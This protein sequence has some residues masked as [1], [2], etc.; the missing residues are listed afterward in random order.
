MHR[1]GES[2]G[3]AEADYFGTVDKEKYVAQTKAHLE[4]LLGENPEKKAALLAAKEKMRSNLPPYMPHAASIEFV[5][6]CQPGDPAAPATEYARRFRTLVLQKLAK[7][8]GPLPEDAVKFYTACSDVQNKAGRKVN[9][10][11][12]QWHGTDALIEVEVPGKGI[13][14]ITIDGSTDPNKVERNPKAELVT[15]FS[16]DLD[17]REDPLGYG[18]FVAGEADKAVAIYKQ[19][20][21]PA[22]SD[23][24]LTA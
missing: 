24:L 11:L 6:A 5:K 2:G 16:D 1:F 18:K 19:K 7:D 20:T 17:A 9:T 10:P 23:Q 12:D 22:E 8:I 4:S 15:I 3:M 13:V 14:V 21:V